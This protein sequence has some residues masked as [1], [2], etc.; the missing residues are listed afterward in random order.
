MH[1]AILDTAVRTDWSALRLP[2]AAEAGAALRDDGFVVVRGCVESRLRSALA[3]LAAATLARYGTRVVRPAG[4]EVLDYRVVTG[5]LIQ[6]HA[7]P[8]FDLYMSSVLLR[9]L[10]G[11]CA[12]PDLGISPHVLSSININC[13]DE[14]GQGYPWHTDA[15]PFT[16]LL[17]LTTL[18]GASGGAFRIRSSRSEEAEIPPVSGDLLVMDGHRCPHAVAALRA[19]I[20]RLTIPMVYPAT[21]VER[22]AG[23]DAYLYDSIAGS[24]KRR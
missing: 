17:F 7:A 9:W 23:L 1:T 20:Q 22:P 10:R 12:V 6:L 21:R 11:A 18:P 14:V 5:D 3:A 8:L 4:S 2:P 24:S 16:A 13:L 15:V 19:P